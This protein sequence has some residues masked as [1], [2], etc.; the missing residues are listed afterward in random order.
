MINFAKFC[1]FMNTHTHYDLGL[2]SI[3]ILKF[4]IPKWIANC[5]FEFL[6]NYHA[7]KN[8]EK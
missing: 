1:K 2:F 3:R 6:E 8:R 7:L 5:E 4:S